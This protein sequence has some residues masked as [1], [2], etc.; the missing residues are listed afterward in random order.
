MEL[1]V[2]CDSMAELKVRKMLRKKTAKHA[3]AVFRHELTDYDYKSKQARRMDRGF[4]GPAYDSVVKSV[5]Q[6]AMSI[7]RN[8]EWMAAIEQW[9][10]RR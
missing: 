9:V 2:R 4:N 6:A 1:N 10:R 5:V 7:T 3:F 8:P